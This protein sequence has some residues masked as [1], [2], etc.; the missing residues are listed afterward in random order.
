MSYRVSSWDSLAFSFTR[1][2]E[3][4]RRMWRVKRFK[5]SAFSPTMYHQL[6][7]TINDMIVNLGRLLYPIYVYNQE[8]F[9]SSWAVWHFLNF[10]A[11]PIL[12]AQRVGSA[13]H[14]AS[15]IKKSLTR[16]R[17]RAILIY[18]S[19]IQLLGKVTI[20][21]NPQK[22]TPDSAPWRYWKNTRRY[23]KTTE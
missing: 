7:E 4:R 8:F 3:P 11:P 19:V 17:S 10:E 21:Y 22:R 15:M 2:A 16:V 18:S 20:S 1:V 23:W 6:S 13:V 5:E 12:P 14:I 9:A